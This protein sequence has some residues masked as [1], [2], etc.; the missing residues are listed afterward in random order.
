MKKEEP[1][2]YQRQ[3][4]TSPSI[5][6]EIAEY[7]FYR[8]LGAVCGIFLRYN[9]LPGVSLGLRNYSLE[10]IP[11]KSY[12]IIG[13]SIGSGITFLSFPGLYDSLV[14]IFVS[15]SKAISYVRYN[16]IV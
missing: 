4:T 8:G 6:K 2:A 1:S 13:A 15:L 5:P 3:L 12:T 16:S 14:S 7:G 9:L 10:E 11:L